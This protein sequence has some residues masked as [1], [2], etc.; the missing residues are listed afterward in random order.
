MGQF[1]DAGNEVMPDP[2]AHAA[3]YWLARSMGAALVLGFVYLTLR[4][5]WRRN[6]TIYGLL[7]LIFVGALAAARWRSTG[8]AHS[9]SPFLPRYAINS[10]FATALLYL[11][12]AEI[13]PGL[14]KRMAPCALALS[15]IFCLLSYSVSLPLARQYA[16]HQRYAI[17]QM[18]NAVYQD[19]DPEFS[20]PSIYLFKYYFRSFSEAVRT[21]VY[22][23]PIES[24]VA[25]LVG[26]P[27]GGR[28][29][30]IP[31]RAIPW[32]LVHVGENALNYTFHL[33]P[34]KLTGP[35][36]H[37]DAPCV[38]LTSAGG[39]EFMFKAIDFASLPGDAVT[40]R[41]ESPAGTTHVVCV[42]K[43]DLPAGPISVAVVVPDGEARGIVRS[44]LALPTR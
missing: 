1:A 5:Y 9:V 40:Y 11:A 34:A 3:T 8:S 38:L 19:S 18:T 44:P 12:L 30:Y 13:H 36:P 27:V 21:G 6:L 20:E 26:E 43:A 10:V 37:T 14:F 31:E 22:I 16:A 24:T 15:A 41:N 32:R 17:L 7:A 25:G 33:G 42:R 2:Q 4:R 23:A 39:D 28:M 29:E 35:V